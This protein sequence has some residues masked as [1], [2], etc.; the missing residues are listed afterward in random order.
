[1]KK[2]CIFGAGGFA[3][4]VYWLARQ[5]YREVD[6]FIDIQ[7]DCN[8]NGIKTETEDY[9]DPN[10]HVAIVA[11]GE[12]HLRKKIT[13]KIQ[14]RYSGR[15]F[16]ILIAPTANIMDSST[17][18][19]YGSVICSNCVIT[20]DVALGPHAQLN[21]ATTIGH[22]TKVGAFF[23][24]APGAHISGKVNIGECVYFGTNSST[25]EGI[26]ICNDVVIGAGACV[27]KDITESG[28]YIGIPA[29]IRRI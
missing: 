24:T 28:I 21:L 1:M 16:D 4:E 8:Y 22:D 18:I 23:T 7:K 15:I 26:N 10:R 17:I 13:T 19:H 5:C 12:P 20:C 3:K 9:F 2:L 29:K 6:A 11:V 25:I 14:D 27:V